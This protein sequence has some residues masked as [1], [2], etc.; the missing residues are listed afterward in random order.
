MKQIKWNDN[1]K[2]WEEKNAFAL[3][4]NIPEF[5]EDVTLPHDA[6][7]LNPAKADSPNQG[8]TGF[9]HI[10]FCWLVQYQRER[11]GINDAIEICFTHGRTYA[12]KGGRCRQSFRQHAF[13]I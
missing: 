7:L 12:R 4:W 8:N 9:F 6:M 1:W 5:A 10:G 2:F 11:H 3:V 13:R